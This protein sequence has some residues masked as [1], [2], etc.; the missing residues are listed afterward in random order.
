[1]RKLLRMEVDRRAG[2]EGEGAIL[3]S[4]DTG[5]NSVRTMRHSSDWGLGEMASVTVYRP[6]AGERCQVTIVRARRGARVQSCYAASE[7]SA[8]RLVSVVN[9]A[10]G[11]GEGEVLVGTDSWTWWTWQATWGRM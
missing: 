11:R 3:A 4:G 10:V 8:Q 7:E 5:R 2:H 6:S 1:M 9:A